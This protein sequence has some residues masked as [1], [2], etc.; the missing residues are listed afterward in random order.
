M[1]VGRSPKITGPYLDREAKSM[2]EGGGS[3]M[4]ETTGPFIGPGH[5]G[6]LKTG[7]RF[8]LSMHFYDGTQR[9]RSTLAI[10][11]LRWDEEGWPVVLQSE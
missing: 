11:P 8:W 10:G 2:A 9:G 3:L 1:R 4:L 5:P 7:D 6:I